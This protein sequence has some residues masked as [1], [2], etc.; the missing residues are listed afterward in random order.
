[1][2]YFSVY[3][4]LHISRDVNGDIIVRCINFMVNSYL[5]G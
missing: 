4:S 3:I 1:M 5:N 2:N